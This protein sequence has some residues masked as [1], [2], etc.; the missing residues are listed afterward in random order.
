MKILFGLLTHPASFAKV[1][2][3]K[4][5]RTGRIFKN[6]RLRWDR[7]ARGRSGVSVSWP[8]LWCHGSELRRLSCPFPAP[9]RGACGEPRPLAGGW[10]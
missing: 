9:R 6:S 8:G 7:K 4:S 5:V 1:A 2:Q 10:A 3:R